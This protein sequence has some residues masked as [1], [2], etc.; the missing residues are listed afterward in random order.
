MPTV[1]ATTIVQG[2]YDILGVTS[3]GETM[4]SAMGTFGRTFLNDML[5]EWAQRRLFIPVIA[6]EQF[7]MEADKGGPDD[8]YTIG[9]DGDFDTQKP[10][11]QG[12]IVAANLVLMASSP[13]VRVPLGI[14][15]DQ[16]YAANQIPGMTSGQPTA[17]YYN[18][19]YADNLGSIYLWPVPDT[20]ENE[21]ELF[22]EK[23]LVQFADLTTEYDVPDG[24]PRALKFNLA[25]TLAQPM[26]RELSPSGRRIAMSSLGTFKRSN[27]KLSDLQNDALWG[28]SSRTI[29]NINTGAGGS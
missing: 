4:S 7:E 6:R 5:S 1:T 17:L 13:E 24:V 19:T 27:T 25:D 15:T 21:L 14:Y 8:P 20:D 9:D 23:A 2:A 28:A 3:A 12:S 11:N 18:P 26:G 22:L 16:A 29:Y 10:A